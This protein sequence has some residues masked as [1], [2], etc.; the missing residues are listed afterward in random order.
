MM[1]FQAFST[2][3]EVALIKAVIS[4]LYVIFFLSHTT[5]PAKNCNIVHEVM[6]PFIDS[7]V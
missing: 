7:R 5:Q 4:T 3:D 2:L 6:N 1:G